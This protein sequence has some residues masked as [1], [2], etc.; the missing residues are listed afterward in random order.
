[1][2]SL[3]PGFKLKL[4][5]LRGEQKSQNWT[6][7]GELVFLYWGQSTRVHRNLSTIWVKM[8]IHIIF[9]L[10]LQSSPLIF[11][12]HKRPAMAFGSP[13]LVRLRTGV[14]W[15][16]FSRH[17]AMHGPGR[18]VTLPSWALLISWREIHQQAGNIIDVKGSV[19]FQKGKQAFVGL[20]Q[21]SM[22]IGGLGP[23]QCQHWF[24]ELR[25]G[26]T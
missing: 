8:V 7:Y 22:Y 13:L 17:W 21:L 16:F 14:N 4:G 18:S 19:Q 23:I 1:M 26:H 9:F 20:E 11:K 25:T 10:P 3:T 15:R 6:V 12:Q 5:G 2:L 24:H